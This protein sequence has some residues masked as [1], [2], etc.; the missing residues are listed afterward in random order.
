MVTFN[1]VAFNVTMKEVEAVIVDMTEAT[2]AMAMAM[3]AYSLK[4]KIA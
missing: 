3:K 1:L 2:R 4:S